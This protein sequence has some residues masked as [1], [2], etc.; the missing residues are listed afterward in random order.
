MKKFIY[1]I[2]ILFF[3]QNNLGAS[4]KKNVINK[5]NKIEN[6]SFN[7]VQTINGKDEKGECT[8]KYPKKIFCNIF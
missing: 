7:F 1:V 8:I 3:L 6:I 5:F 4:S 2:I